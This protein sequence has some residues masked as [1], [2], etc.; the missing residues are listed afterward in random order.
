MDP[1]DREILVLRHYEQMSNGDAAAAL[2]LRSRRRASGTPGPGAA[3]EDPRSLPGGTSGQDHER[4][5]R[6]RPFRGRR[7]I[8]P[9]AVSGRGA[10]SIDRVRRPLPRAGRQIRE[11]L[12]ALVTVEQD[13]SIDV[14]AAPAAGHAVAGP[15]EAAGRLPDPPGDRPGR[16]GGGLR[17]RAGQ[18]GP[19]GGTEG[20]ARP[21]RARPPGL[22]RFRREAK[23]AARLHHTNIVP[24]FEVGQEGEVAYYAMQFIQGQGL[25]QVIAELRRLLAPGLDAGEAGTRRP[26]GFEES[27]TLGASR[28]FLKS[29]LPG[30]VQFM[31][32]TTLHSHG[33][34]LCRRRAPIQI[35]QPWR[36]PQPPPGRVLAG[37]QRVCKRHRTL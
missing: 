14:D 35:R 24:V 30:L 29:N 27:T 10:S 32:L 9:G 15:V 7:R 23:S 21:G 5:H 19:P 3:R 36:N 33:P 17:G 31:S 16:H 13:L 28:V 4:D 34:E 1:L 20:P 25:D 2:G 37:I 8:V 12:P 11:L 18:P 26:D 22:E 6:S